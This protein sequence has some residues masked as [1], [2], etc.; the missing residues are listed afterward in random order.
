MKRNIFIL[1]SLLLLATLAKGQMVVNIDTCRNLAVKN[2]KEMLIARKQHEKAQYVK[3]EQQSNYFPKF[4]ASGTYMYTDLKQ[5][6]SIED[7]YFPTSNFNPSTGQL[8]TNLALDPTGNP[9]MDEAGNPVFNTYAFIPAGNIG[10]NMNNTIYASVGADQPIY[11]GGKISAANKMAEVGMDLSELNI[12]DR[13]QAVIV[14]ADKTYWTYVSVIDQKKVARK[15][16]SLLDSLTTMVSNSVDAGL[17][18]R[19]ELLKVQVK[20]NEVQLQYDDAVN[21]EE[22]LRMSLCRIM[23]IDLLTQLS[24]ADTIID[25]HGAFILDSDYSSIQNRTDYQMLQKNIDLKKHNEKLIRADFLPQVGVRASYDYLKAFEIDNASASYGISNGYV[26]DGGNFSFM[27]TV[28]IPLF[29]WGE[30]KNKIK[31]AK[32]DTEI[33]KAEFDKYDKLMH[34]ELI[35]ARQSLNQAYNRY[36]A[37][38]K[39]LEQAE[40]NMKISKDTYE[41][42]MELLTD[43]LD[44]QAQWQTAYA[45]FIKSKTDYKIA[46]TIYSKAIGEL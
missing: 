45:D 2:S 21:A 28:S 32:I 22:L 39:N 33:A 5:D 44:A 37:A 12:E 9:I 7:T 6:I 16:L 38:N 41:A 43:Y 27:A 42:G 18:H 26:F 30:G 11:T 23:G 4:S 1:I 15:Y 17:T 34:L 20:R 31:Q 14:E 13:R 29:Q 25:I 46:R 24:V 10:Y 36:N 40:E 3:K 19:N 8:E 35:Q